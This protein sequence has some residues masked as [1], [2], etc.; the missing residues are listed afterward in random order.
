[1]NTIE[2]TTI[3]TSEP[4]PICGY[5]AQLAGQTTHCTRP[6]TTCLRTRY[7]I[8]ETWLCDFHAGMLAVYLSQLEEQA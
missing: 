2:T 1:M 3:V 8:G 4:P 7:N 5:F 6:A